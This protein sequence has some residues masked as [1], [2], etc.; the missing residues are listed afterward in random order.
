MSYNSQINDAHLVECANV[1]IKQL[2]HTICRLNPD[3]N[4]NPNVKI[5]NILYANFLYIPK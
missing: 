1:I 2:L 5:I 4:P 3:P